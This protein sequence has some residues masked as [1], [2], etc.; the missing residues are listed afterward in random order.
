MW[1]RQPFSERT[2]EQNLVV[3]DVVKL[4]STGICRELRLPRLFE[5]AEWRPLFLRQRVHRP[6]G[7]TRCA[8]PPYEKARL[9][10]GS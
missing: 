2:G 8:G 3:Y 4:E 6:L 7:R 10:T 9:A 5:V 1:L